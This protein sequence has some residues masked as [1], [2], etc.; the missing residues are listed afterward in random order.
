MFTKLK[1][2]T[3]FFHSDLEKEDKQDIDNAANAAKRQCMSLLGT[4]TLWGNHG[5]VQDIDRAEALLEPAANAG[6]AFAMYGLGM[7]FFLGF[8][9]CSRFV[10]WLQSICSVDT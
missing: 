1:Y 4:F 5:V 7:L 6:D 9:R 2:F 3:K 8:R 10:L